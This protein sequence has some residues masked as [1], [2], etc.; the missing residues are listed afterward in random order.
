MGRK[1]KPVIAINNETHER[2]LY[3]CVIECAQSLRVSSSA[4]L[5]A[6]ARNTS[7]KGWRLYDTPDN[8]R[9][10]IYDLEKQIVLLESN[11]EGVSS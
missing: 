6:V 8:I 5:V 10:R 2:K 4:V 9:Q 3:N 11:K 1:T 7:V